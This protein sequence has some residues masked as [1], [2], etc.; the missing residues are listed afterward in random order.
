MTNGVLLFAHSND[1]F[2]YSILA[3]ECARRVHK[4]LK[5]PVCLVTSDEKQYRHVD[6]VIKVKKPGSGNLRSFTQ[7]QTGEFFNE[8]RYNSYSVSPFD[9]TLVIDVDYFLMSDRLN[10]VWDLSGFKVSHDA[11]N[12]AG[13]SITVTHGDLRQVWATILYF[14]RSEISRT[15][16]ELAGHVYMNWDFYAPFYSVPLQPRR[17]DFAFAI[18]VRLL[19]KKFKDVD[20]DLGISIVTANSTLNVVELTD[21]HSRFEMYENLEIKSDIHIINK[22]PILDLLNVHSL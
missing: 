1:L 7:H 5:V 21:D 20:T 15:L 11:V 13:N 4:F 14:D 17:N 19:E 6:E 22:S 18:A 16:F 8:D 12:L 9:R 10:S 2:D 3:D